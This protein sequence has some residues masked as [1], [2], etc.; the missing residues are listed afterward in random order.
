M[1]QPSPEL[2]LKSGLTSK[3]AIL[4]QGSKF[5]CQYGVIFTLPVTLAMVVIIVNTGHYEFIGL[6][7]TH[8]QATE[9]LLKRWDEHCER[10]PDAESGYMQ[11]LIEEGSAQVVEMEPGSAVIYGL[12]G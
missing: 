11:E 7:E 6:G 2:T 4:R 1:S 9:G 8:G 10:N 12:D 5:N 3:T